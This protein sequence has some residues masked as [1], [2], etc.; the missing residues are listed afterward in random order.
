MDTN[1]NISVIAVVY[2]EAQRIENFLK[3]FRWSNDLIIVDKSSTDN[4]RDIVLQY[5]PNLIIVP[6][7]DTGDEIKYGVEI[8]KNEWIMTVT[9]SDTIHPE[10]VFELLNLINREDFD[11]DVVSLPFALY[12]FGI[13]NPKRSPWRATSKKLLMKKTALKTSTEVHHEISA[14]SNKIYKMGYRE[15]INLYHLTHENM[16][17]FFERHNRYTR[18]EAGLFQDEKIALKTSLRDLFE[19]INFILF[20]KKSYLLGWD[21]IAVGLAYISYY[22]MKYL[23][24]WER[25]RGKGSDVYKDIHQQIFSIWDARPGDTK[26]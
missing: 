20:K 25:F 23:Y 1:K 24:V 18:L 4:T 3:S 10:L 2:N 7:S 16:A 14:A 22:I 26:K 12:V 15:K 17:T 5:T 8:A 6:Y 9:A 21:G 19:S 13:R 11:C